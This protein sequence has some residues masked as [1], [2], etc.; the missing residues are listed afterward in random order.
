MPNNGSGILGTSMA[1]HDTSSV[2]AASQIY[3]EEALKIGATLK[4][5][6][7]LWIIPLTLVFAFLKKSDSKITFPWFIL[8]FLLFSLAF[9]FIQPIRFLIPYFS[10]ISKAGLSLTLFQTIGLTF[11]H[12]CSCSAKFL[13]KIKI[14]TKP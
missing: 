13:A 11:L 3:G 5:T 10:L 4:L 1:I 6:R 7:A 9:T 12:I 8:Y 2:V 14:F